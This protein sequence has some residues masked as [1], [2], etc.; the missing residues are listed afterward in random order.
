MKRHTGLLNKTV[1]FSIL[2]YHGGNYE[3]NKNFENAIKFYA[4]VADNFP[5]YTRI[6]VKDN[7]ISCVLK[8]KNI[9]DYSQYPKVNINYLL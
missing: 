5:K 9:N 3:Y 4:F 1:L 8:S 6:E 2:D 7:L